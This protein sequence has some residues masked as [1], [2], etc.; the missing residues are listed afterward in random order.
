MID[1]LFLAH[2]LRHPLDAARMLWRRYW[3]DRDVGRHVR[4]GGEWGTI[5]RCHECGGSGRLHR[6]DVMP[7][8]V[9]PQECPA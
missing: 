7:G 9:D 3:R 6:L 2:A 1:R 8:P 5:V 4:D